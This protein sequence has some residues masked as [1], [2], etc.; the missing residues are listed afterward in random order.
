VKALVT[1]GLG[2]IGISLARALAARGTHLVLFDF[3]GDGDAAPPGAEVVLG[4]V[5]DEQLVRRLVADA[6]VVFHLASV[7]SGGGERDFDRAFRVNLDGGRN[8][9]EACRAT[10]RRPRLVFPSTLAVF[11]GAAMPETVSDATRAT[12][13]T[14]Y[15]ATKAACELL[16]SD[17]SRKGYLDGRVARLPTVVIRPGAPNEA[18]SSFASAV[19]REP[20]A[21]RDYTLPVALETRIPVIGIRTAVDGLLRLAELPAEALGD[22][23]VLNLP[24]IS[25]TV[26][27]MLDSLH[28]VAGKRGL[29]LGAVEVREDPEIAAVVRTWPRRVV[30]ERA[31]ELGLSQDGD[32][33]AIVDAYLDELVR[34]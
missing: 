20:L 2:F 16:V 23:R 9:F 22:D 1:G 6:D 14:T 28:R 4:D 21:G 15:G 32:L 26:G 8:V 33:D 34:S 17:Y 18:A 10:G 11:G 19:F 25:V 3:D 30:A 12:P 5:C 29:A 27:E 13:Q 31:L 7:V 24:G